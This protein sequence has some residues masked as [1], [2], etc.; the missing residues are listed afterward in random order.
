MRAALLVAALVLTAPLEAQLPTGME[1]EAIVGLAGQNDNQKFDKLQISPVGLNI[2][3]IVQPLFGRRNVSL[4]EQVS[5]FPVIYYERDNPFDPSSG[6]PRTN[7]LIINS[8]WLRVA[9]DEPEAE[10]RNVFFAGFGLG[11]AVTTPRDGDKVSPMI[12]V[13]MRRWFPRQLGF[14]LSLQCAVL[15]LGR[16]VC[17]MPITSV[18]PF[19]NSPTGGS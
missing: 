14:E 19:G 6:P 4:A 16:T 9:T 1:G 15:Q 7:P 3:F 5:F 18:W 10:D 17:Q 12:G 8:L 11:L 13:G 2:G